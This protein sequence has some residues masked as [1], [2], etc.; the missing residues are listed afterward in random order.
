MPIGSEFRGIRS[1]DPCCEKC[2]GYCPKLVAVGYPANGP[3]EVGAILRRS[4]DWAALKFGC[5]CDC[6]LNEGL[7]DV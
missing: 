4:G 6:A 5:G 2:P 7:F 3:D 1:G